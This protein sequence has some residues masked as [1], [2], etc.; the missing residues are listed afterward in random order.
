MKKFMLVN[1]LALSLLS[2]TMLAHA[3]TA[4]PPTISVLKAEKKPIAEELNV[5]GSFAAGELVLVTPEIEG[6]AVTEFLAEEGDMVKKGQVLARLNSNTIDIQIQ[7]AKASLARNDLSIQQAQNQIDQAQISR[8]KADADLERTK[9]L[10]ASGVATQQTLDQMKATYDLAA[11]QLAA[12][13]LSLLGAKTDRLGLEANMA[14]LQLNKS[15]TEIKAPVDGY[16]SS[17]NVQIGGIASGQKASM[18]EIVA[19]ATVKLLAEVPESD[20]PRVKIGQKA[21]ITVNGFDKPIEGEVKLISPTVNQQTRIGIAH[22]AVTSDKR[23]ALGAF[24]RARIALADAQGVALPLTAVTF[25]DNG[26]TV[27]IVKDGKVQVR[28]VITGLVGTDDIEITDG[29]EPGETFVARA[30]SF[31]RDGDAVTPVLMAQ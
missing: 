20:L 5:T 1:A 31:V 17:R 19:N 21:A 24:G 22:I 18:Y 10:R 27:Q 28:K 9:T 3:D 6:L 25:G 13:Q 2:G 4:A 7:Q 12:A 29:V 30:G 8:D 15:R 16:I 14:S 11:A 26:P 23:I